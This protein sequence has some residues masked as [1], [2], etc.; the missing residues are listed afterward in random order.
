MRIHPRALLL[1]CAAAA[2]TSTAMAGTVNVSFVDA[3]RFTDVGTTRWDEDANLKVLAKHLAGLGQR[4]LPADQV[5]TIEVLD[6]DLAGTVWPSRGATADVR[7]VKGGAD[8]P[9]ITLRYSL[10]QPGKPVRRGEETVSDMNYTHG[11]TSTI[12]TEPLY[13]EKRM[14]DEW[15]KAR[16]GEHD[17]A[18]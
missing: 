13:H 15:F 5:M 3:Q 1:A 12:G 9:R 2:V 16:F 11:R 7:I 17:A 18:D 6:V 8:W 14:L 10:E 4:Y